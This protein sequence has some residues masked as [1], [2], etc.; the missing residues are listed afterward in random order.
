MVKPLLHCPTYA[1]ST[2]QERNARH[3]NQ[4]YNC[5]ESRGDSL[6]KTVGSG[7][8]LGW[9]KTPLIGCPVEKIPLAGIARSPQVSE[10]KLRFS[11]T[12]TP[13]TQNHPPTNQVQ[14]QPRPR[15]RL[16]VQMDASGRLPN[17]YLT[18]TIKI[19][20]GQFSPDLDHRGSQP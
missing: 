16:T 7:D 2:Q 13:T 18:L 14:V 19:L 9:H 15:R 8:G 3:G 11:S 5:R 10:R 20:A 1:R 12:L 17:L 6:V 4:N